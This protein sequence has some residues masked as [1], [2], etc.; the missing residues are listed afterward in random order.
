MAKDP[1]QVVGS[2]IVTGAIL[3]FAALVIYLTCL[4]GDGGV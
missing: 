2:F 3:Q 1:V 4:D